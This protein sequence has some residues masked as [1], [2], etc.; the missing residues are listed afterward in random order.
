MFWVGVS[1]ETRAPCP[2]SKAERLA[3]PGPKGEEARRGPR[4][5][6]P[7]RE[8]A[9]ATP[10]RGRMLTPLRS[11]HNREATRMFSASPCLC[12]HTVFLQADAYA[13]LSFVSSSLE[14]DAP[15]AAPYFVEAAVPVW[16]ELEPLEVSVKAE[17]WRHLEQLALE[18]PAYSSDGIAT[19]PTRHFIIRDVV[20]AYQIS[21]SRRTI[22]LLE[23]GHSLPLPG[24]D[25]RSSS[26][27]DQGAD[28]RPK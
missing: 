25:G 12:A 6:R 10:R 28:Q 17:L 4:H 20:V 3:Y 14:R 7:V 13:Q 9:R 18:A 5:P 15:A 1:S 23:L 22:T 11:L 19:R 26:P 8:R 24:A 27:S 21:D 16:R 2:G